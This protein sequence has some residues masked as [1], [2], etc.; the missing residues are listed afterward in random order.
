MLTYPL[1]FASI[2]GLVLGLGTLALGLPFDPRWAFGGATVAVLVPAT[3]TAL[4]GMFTRRVGG[5][6]IAV[7]AMLGALLLDE[8]LTGAVIAVMMTGGAAL[9]AHALSRA[10]REL[11]ALLQRAPQVAHRK[12]GTSLTDVSVDQVQVGDVLVVKSS[13]VVPADGVLLA[14]ATLDES[15]L[16]GEARPVPRAAGS[17]VCSGALN[18]GGALELRVSARATDSTYAAIV[19]LVRNAEQQRAPF[20]RLADRYAHYFLGLALVTSGLAWWWS[21]ELSRALAVLV[22]ATPCPLII[23]VPVAMVAGIS[24]AAR[25]GILVKGGAALEALARAKL[26]LLDKT[27][28]VTTSKPEVIGVESF[29][30]LSAS[31][32]V[33]AAAAMEQLASHA[34]APAILRE[35]ARREL[36]LPLPTDVHELHGCG[37]E[38]RVDGKQVAVGQLAW[39]APEGN[40]LARVHSLLVRNAAEGADAAYVAIEGKLEGALI[41]QN[42]IRPEAPR[43]IESLRRTGIRAVHLVTGDHRDIADLVGD[44]IGVDRVYAERTP[45]EKAELV[46]QLSGQGGIVVVGDGINDAPALA[47]ADV[48]VAMGVRGA[49]AAS[50]SADI[51]LTRDRL[52][53]L[54]TARQIALRTRRIAQSSVL[55]GMALSGLAMAAAAAGMLPPLYGALLQEAID[56]LVILNALRALGSGRRRHPA[57]LSRLVQSA[58]GEH[59]D[60]L[61]EVAELA[62]LAGS[63]ESLSAEEARV[64]LQRVRE[65]LDTRL[66]PHEQREQS[67]AYPALRA[68]MPSEDPT[69]PLI[70]THHEIRRRARLF[71]RLLERLPERGPGRED[72]PDLRRALYGLHAVLTLH[73]A[74]E[75]ELYASVL[76][77]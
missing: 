24:R 72:L 76:P 25:E 64:A 52:E 66:L 65:L 2:G 67:D 47:R 55:A 17:A 15:A 31:T 4:R 51:V 1:L 56:V 43:V 50:E 39:L 34:F 41:M 18:T 37:I 49:S 71:S 45:G 68:L 74:Q 3:F 12:L 38:G 6:L 77:A 60:L 16:T 40:R 36:T 33:H 63:L 32:L 30:E 28:T 73:F 9:E 57:A 53:G 10:R 14:G 42:P 75:D 23:A 44:A 20:V 46:Q 11:S 48:G 61:P 21:G 59:G 8:T 5:D 26:V 29:G 19:R 58:S 7:L 13:E 69:T 62:E 27:G 54:L 35:A 70:Q 22:V